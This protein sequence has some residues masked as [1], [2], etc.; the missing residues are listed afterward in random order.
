[1]GRGTGKGR[2]AFPLQGGM[3]AAQ[4]GGQVLRPEKGR[5]AFRGL[6]ACR[7][8][9]GSIG[10]D[11]TQGIV[12]DVAQK[13]VRVPYAAQQLAGRA[14]I[15]IH[16]GQPVLA[17][18]GP[19]AAEDGK[20][21]AQDDAGVVDGLLVQGTVAAGQRMQGPCLPLQ[22]GTEMA[23]EQLSGR[24]GLG[25]D[26]RAGIG[27]EGPEPFQGG[28]A[29]QAFPER[30]MDD[31]LFAQAQGRADPDEEEDRGLAGQAYLQR[32]EAQGEAGHL[33]DGRQHHGGAP[34]GI[35]RG[36]A[37]AGEQ[38]LHLVR[39]PLAHGEQGQG[40]GQQPVGIGIEAFEGMG[41]H[42]LARVGRPVAQLHQRMDQ[43]GQRGQPPV[44]TV[45]GGQPGEDGQDKIRFPPA[46]GQVD[47]EQTAKA[48]EPAGAQGGGLIAQAACAAPEQG[49]GREGGSFVHAASP[50]LVY[51][52]KEA[53]PGRERQG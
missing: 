47:A 42:D 35:V 13:H 48:A 29:E 16:G 39:A 25:R 30:G 32:I 41:E 23:A 34:P 52:G 17:Q 11:G 31:Q 51:A 45:P 38:G 33:H 43:D 24:R 18:I 21:A 44:Q 22:I 4:P 8:G 46:G 9:S 1:M 53:C 40:H 15:R 50:W 28:L 3:Q 2:G 6:P 14:Q 37:H 20:Q 19:Q 5:S 26:G 36:A 27:I 10:G 7:G 49:A 12:P